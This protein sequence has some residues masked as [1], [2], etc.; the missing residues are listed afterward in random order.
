[1]WGRCGAVRLF[2][3]FANRDDRQFDI[4]SLDSSIAAPGPERE[5]LPVC[6]P[7]RPVLTPASQLTQEISRCKQFNV[8]SDNRHLIFAMALHLPC[9]ILPSRHTVR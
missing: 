4:C 2:G 7:I 5:T 8:S 9:E 1:M 6:I 3:M